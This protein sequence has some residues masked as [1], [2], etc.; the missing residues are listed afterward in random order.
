[1]K[2]VIARRAI[3]AG[4]KESIVVFGQGSRGGR[5]VFIC[6]LVAPDRFVKRA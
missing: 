2:R 3:E 5:V 6:G 4:G 1:M